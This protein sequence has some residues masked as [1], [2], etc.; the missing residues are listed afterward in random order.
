MEVKLFITYLHKRHAKRRRIEWPRR[1]D[2]KTEDEVEWYVLDTYHFCYIFMDSDRT[3]GLFKA[4]MAGC[5]DGFLLWCSSVLLS[6]LPN[7]V[8][9]ATF[10][11]A[12][13]KGLVFNP[14]R[15]RA[16]TVAESSRLRVARCFARCFSRAGAYR[17]VT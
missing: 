1:A 12:A 15:V 2:P 10:V 7:W 5:T 17:G 14:S 13:C 11:K 4:A 3:S 16:G 9:Y 8:W 6:V